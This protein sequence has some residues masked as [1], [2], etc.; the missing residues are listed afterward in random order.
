MIKI[1]KRKK[2]KRH[3][4]LLFLIF[5]CFNL[6]IYFILRRK[7]FL[8]LLERIKIEKTEYNSR[9]YISNRMIIKKEIDSIIYKSTKIDQE[10]TESKCKSKFQDVK[11]NKFGDKIFR[12][13]NQVVVKSNLEKKKKRKNISLE[14]RGI[15]VQGFSIRGRK[16]EDASRHFFF[17]FSPY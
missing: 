12:K 17:F 15:I 14:Q 10:H 5:K 3:I 2:R 7:Y 8:S 11:D 9:N 16:S 1:S 6:L 13:W 4:F